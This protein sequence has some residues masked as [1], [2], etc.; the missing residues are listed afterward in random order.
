MK[1]RKPR[2]YWTEERCLEV[3]LKCKT[4]KEF[5]EKYSG[6]R[7]SA[8]K[9]GWIEKCHKH[10]IYLGNYYKRLIY[11]VL[12]PDKSV[13]V[14]LTY[15]PEKR[16][17]NHLVSKKSSVYKH[18][19][20]TGL[21][22]EFK[23]LTKLI[24]KQEASIKEGVFESN[25]RKKGYNILNKSK[26]GVLGG[27]VTKWTKKSCHIEALKYNSRYEFKLNNPSA[28]NASHNSYWIDDITS[29][30]TNGIRPIGYWHNKQNCILEAKKYKYRSE[31][32]KKNSTAYQ[33]CCKN[34]WL[35]ECCAHMI[36]KKR[37]L[38]CNK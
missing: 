5:V 23:I 27:G 18:I 37:Q 35:N 20:N 21:S 10:M 4:R 2:G 7:Y 8:V 17:K 3:A 25:Y 1:N 29:H 14:G 13:Y 31:F 24:D 9:N 33:S 6:A 34:R 26:T 38:K 11:A 22:P 30:M 28:Y 12:F 15:N 19:K 16:F 36:P 32:K